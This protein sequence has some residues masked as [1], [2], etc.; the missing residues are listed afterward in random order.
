MAKTSQLQ[1]RVSEEQKQ[2]LKDAAARE[3]LDV[4]TYVLSKALPQERREFRALVAAVGSGRQHRAALAVL[5]DFLWALSP[6]AFAR[7]V[8][9]PPSVLP[10]FEANYVAAMV[11]TAANR[12][13]VAPPAWTQDIPPLREPW[14]ASSLKSLRLH[15]LCESPVAFRRR[16]LFV[17]STVGDRV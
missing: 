4:S 1:I 8:E 6:A 7:A 3:G 2:A 5:N 14:F 11:E 13:R 15:L 12:K 17:D 10:P 16:N 9:E